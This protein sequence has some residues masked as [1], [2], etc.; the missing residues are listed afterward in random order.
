MK[1]QKVSVMLMMLAWNGH[2]LKADKASQE[3][4]LNAIKDKRED[5]K[6]KITQEV[7]MFSHSL[8]FQNVTLD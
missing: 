8:N 6:D 3:E 5:L 4:A 7:I 1:V 2:A